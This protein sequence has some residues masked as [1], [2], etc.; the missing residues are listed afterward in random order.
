MIHS[1]PKSQTVRFP[2]WWISGQNGVGHVSKSDLHW[3]NWPQNMM[4]KLKS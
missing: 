1:K 4:A 3:K 2:Y